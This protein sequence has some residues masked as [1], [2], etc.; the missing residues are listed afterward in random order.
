MD[1]I[2]KITAQIQTLLAELEGLDLNIAEDVKRSFV[3]KEK[4]Q[5]YRHKRSIL[6]RSKT[7]GKGVSRS[8]SF[9]GFDSSNTFGQVFRALAG[10]KNV[11]DEARALVSSGSALIQSENIVDEVVYSL[12]S[13]NFLSGAGVQYV[14]TTN[15]RQVPKI[16]SYPTAQWITEGQQVSDSQP[17]IEALKWEFKDLAVLVK[18]QNNVLN[19]AAVSV[20]GL[21]NQVANNAINDAIL[22]AVLYGSGSSGQPLGIDNYTGVLTVDMATDGAA[23]T[24]YTKHTEA[25]KKLL[26]T[27]NDLD[28][29]SFVQSPTSFQQVNDLQV[30]LGNY[31]LPPFDYRNNSV[32]TTSAVKEDYDQGTTANTTRIYVGD[33][34]K[35][36]IGVGDEISV[37]LV[38]RYADYLQTAF[39]VH[40][41]VDIKPLFEDSF[42]IIKGITTA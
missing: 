32:F 29:I 10:S 31:Q 12:Q 13:S 23:I 11:S 20:E 4:L 18:V 40:M 5:E 24:D 22:K 37:K 7:S 33:F 14:A 34:S 42:C 26:Q 19:D 6:E 27:N 9:G 35:L 28:K 15:N 8:Y 36:V 16:S 1:A 38:E 3:I 21:I 30:E 2:K 39:M 17:S 25:V 41:R